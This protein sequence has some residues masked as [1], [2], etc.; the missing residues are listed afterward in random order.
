MDIITDALMEMSTP[1][2]LPVIFTK[3]NS[4]R[5][6]LLLTSIADDVFPAEERKNLSLKE[7]T[8]SLRFDTHLKGRQK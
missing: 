4:F 1:P 2:C 3:G 6:I 7:P 5:D 8:F